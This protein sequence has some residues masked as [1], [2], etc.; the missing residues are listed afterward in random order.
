MKTIEKAKQHVY[1]VSFRTP[2]REGGAVDYYFSSLAA[3][4]EVFS[5]AEIGCKVER[6]WA[7]G[8][9]DGKPYEGRKCTVT[10][11]MVHRKRQKGAV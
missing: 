11:E 7:V 8:V 6:L 10:R 1:R 3:I 2:P 9:S 5:K 4:Y